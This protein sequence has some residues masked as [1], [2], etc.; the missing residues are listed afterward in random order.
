M[1]WLLRI[2]AVLLALDLASG[3]FGVFVG[4]RAGGSGAAATSGFWTPTRIAGNALL[5]LCVVAWTWL[6]VRALRTPWSAPVALAGYVLVRLLL[7]AWLVRELP[8]VDLAT[9]LLLNAFPLGGLLVAILTLIQPPS[10][11]GTSAP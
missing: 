4:L 9:A 1:K 10:E 7:G 2:A 5:L 8:D 11:P 6:A 3:L